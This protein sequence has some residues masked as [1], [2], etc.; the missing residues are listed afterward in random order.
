MQK[1][2]VKSILENQFV[3]VIIAPNFELGVL[4]LL[5]AKPNVR[6]LT[7]SPT[8]KQ[9]EAVLRFNSVTGGVLVQEN[10]QPNIQPH[11][12]QIVSKRQPSSQ[13]IKDLSFAWKVVKFVKSNAIVYV[14][15][16]MTLGIGAGQTSR[17]FSTQI[18]IEKAKEASLGLAHAVMASDAFFPFRDSIDIAAQAGITA[19]IQPGGSI[20]DSE[21]IAAADELGLVMVF[22]R[23]R[24][25]RH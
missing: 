25:F 17:V 11:E 5:A 1:E 2:T 12:W 14:K 23:I 7:I 24:H 6:L 8:A 21:V 19:V 15:D 22:T 20:K 13:Q 3:E 4:E 9:N 18:A 16:E 10:D